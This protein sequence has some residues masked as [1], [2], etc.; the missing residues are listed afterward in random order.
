M[1]LKKYLK[2]KYFPSQITNKKERNI[3]L[4]LIILIVYH[5]IDFLKIRKG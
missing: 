2:L 3:N 5:E 1:T 4:T